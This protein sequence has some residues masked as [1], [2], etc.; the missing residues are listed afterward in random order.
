MA[1]EGVAVKHKLTL[2][3]FA[4]KTSAIHLLAS[5]DKNL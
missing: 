5:E 1:G 4:I 3:L 2:K